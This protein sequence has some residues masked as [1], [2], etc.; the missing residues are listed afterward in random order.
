METPWT[1]T[2]ASG[3]HPTGMHSYFHYSLQMFKLHVKL[4]VFVRRTKIIVLIK[5]YKYL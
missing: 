5:Q 1:A 4:V 2:A 3:T